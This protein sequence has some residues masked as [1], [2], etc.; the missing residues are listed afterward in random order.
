[1]RIEKHREVLEEV[2]QTIKD[3]LDDP[4]GLL[5]HQRRLIA[6]LSL[7]ASQLL[8]IYFHKLDVIK[9]GTQIKHEWFKMGEKNAL[10]R[11]SAIL[12]SDPR[13]IPKINELL[14]FAREIEKDR[15]DIMYGSPLAG[16]RSLKEKIDLWL[17]LKKIVGE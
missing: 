14:S 15:D 3:A 9:P 1:M 4:A 6:M 5:A 11:L 17:E 10:I 2:S 8:E 7:G 12:T 16:D 13:K